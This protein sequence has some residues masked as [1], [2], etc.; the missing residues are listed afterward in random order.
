V[1]AES[2]YEAVAIA[3]AQLREDE[4]SPTDPSPNTEFTVM[5]Y[6]Q[7]AEHRLRDLMGLQGHD[8]PVRSLA[9][10]PNGKRLATGDD[11]GIAHVWAIDHVELLRFLPLII[12]SLVL[13]QSTV[14]QR[15]VV[16]SGRSYFRLWAVAPMIGS[17]TMEDPMRPKY[18][19][20]PNFQAPTSRSGI[21]GY[22]FVKGDDGMALVQYVAADRASLNQILA[23]PTVKSF[24]SGRDKQSDLETEFLKHIKSFDFAHFGVKVQ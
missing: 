20:A 19:P 9:W 17:G 24:L 4:L 13:I 22:Q 15:S 16:D 1:D 3:V 14:A 6:R 5:V 8:Y 23:D 21:I 18:V 10:S 11:G 7:P 2:L 12:S